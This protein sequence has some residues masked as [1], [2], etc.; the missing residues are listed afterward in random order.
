MNRWMI[1]LVAISKKLII[2]M[3]R[4]IQAKLIM[5]STNLIQMQSKLLTQ[6]D[7]GMLK[8][9]KN[10]LNLLSNMEL[11]IGKKLHLIWICEQMFNV[12]I[13]GKKF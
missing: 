2:I 4:I 3:I 10:S 5:N 9:I 7:I 12:Y 11:K 6:K 13:D 1:D 8:R